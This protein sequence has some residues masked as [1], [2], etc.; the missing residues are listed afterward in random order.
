MKKFDNLVFGR[1][2][3]RSLLYTNKQSKQRI[4]QSFSSSNSESN[5]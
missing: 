2:G 1:G 3:G 5:A 4:F